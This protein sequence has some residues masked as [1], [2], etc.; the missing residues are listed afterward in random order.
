MN[1]NVDIALAMCLEDLT[2]LDCSFHAAA[3]LKGRT[4][5]RKLFVGNPEKRFSLDVKQRKN[6]LQATVNI[7]FDLVDHFDERAQG[8]LEV[9]H[10][11]IVGGAVISAPIMGDAA[12][13]PRHLAGADKPEDHRDQ[14][15]ERAMRLEAI[16][17]VYSMAIGKL[18]ELSSM[19]PLG[20]ITLP[21]I[22]SD[23]M[24][25]DIV[26]RERDSSVK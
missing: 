19:S 1:D 7:Q 17:A 2:L 25:D 23:E 12:I 24:L 18:A 4:L 13:A 3:S 26:K 11:G 20:L 16:K 21:L 8:D 6:V 15:M 14:A 5:E 22:D 10:F 9:M